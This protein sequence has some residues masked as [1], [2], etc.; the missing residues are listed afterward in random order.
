MKKLIRI[1]TILI[2]LLSVVLNTGCAPMMYDTSRRFWDDGT[3][4][5]TVEKDWGTPI[6]SS[7][8][9]NPM[10]NTT[11]YYYLYREYNSTREGQTFVYV[12]DRV[13]NR[14]IS[15][16]DLVTKLFYFTG[17]YKKSPKIVVL[18]FN[19]DLPQS[20]AEDRRFR[21]ISVISS[22]LL[23]IK[24]IERSQ[25]DLILKEHRFNMTMTNM[26]DNIQLGRLVGANYMVN[27]NCLKYPNINTCDAIATLINV[28]TGQ[29]EATAEEAIW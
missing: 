20:E 25:I 27:V 29:I 14:N 21:F 4:R 2:L 10:T 28:E 3:S 13:V 9:F 5:E 22:E 24:I 8:Y 15:Y 1:M 19:T 26:A 23:E 11:R 12:N 6:K 17:V 18:P 16:V 7:S